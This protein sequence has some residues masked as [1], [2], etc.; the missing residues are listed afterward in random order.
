MYS[1]QIQENTAQK[2]LRIWTLFTQLTAS[3]LVKSKLHLEKHISLVSEFNLHFSNFVLVNNEKDVKKKKERDRLRN[4]P[5]QLTYLLKYFELRSST[6]SKIL[7]KN[8]KVLTGDREN[9]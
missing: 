9:K 7:R 2:K 5:D 6:V 1:V 4:C 8:L 3:G